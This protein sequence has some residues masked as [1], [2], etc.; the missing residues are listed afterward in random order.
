MPLIQHLANHLFLDS[1]IYKN[2]Y[3]ETYFIKLWEL[4]EEIYVKIFG[5]KQILGYHY[6]YVIA[7]YFLNILVIPI[8]HAKLKMISIIY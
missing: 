1:F 7:Y 6:H 5:T 8:C 3:N 2:N 4:R